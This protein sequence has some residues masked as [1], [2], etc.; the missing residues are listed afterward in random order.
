MKT[1]IQIPT[2]KLLPLAIASL[3][4]A[5]T[6]PASAAITAYRNLILG[7]N[8]IA[9]Y[10]FDETSGTNAANSATTGAA[11]DAAHNGAIN[12]G[13][14]SAKAFLNTSY[15]FAGGYAV[16]AAIPNSL[17]EW[18]LEAWVNYSS[19]KISDSHIVS[20]D[21]GGWNDDV[22][23]G[24]NPENGNLGAGAG[25]VGAGHQDNAS[26]TRDFAGFA[27][28]ADT[29]HHVAVTASN[30]SGLLSLYIDGSFVV[31]NTNA[32]STW[33]FNGADGFGAAPHF[34]IGAKRSGGG[35]EYDGLLDELAI[36]GTVLSASD[37]AARANFTPVPEPSPTALL[38]LGG[39]ALI[40]RR[41][42]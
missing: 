37:I 35:S 34:T 32:N 21:Q 12:H 24:L 33:T 27:M 22:F 13:L 6:L 4:I 31:S 15:D 23:F 40:L 36:Y 26:T 5:S 9:Y 3:A 28:S 38:G 17:T 16:A 30:T 1:N 10:E 11:L 25:T 14:T 29:W 41:R 20:N 42:R 39:L 7:D 8:P 19:D 2:R 18:T